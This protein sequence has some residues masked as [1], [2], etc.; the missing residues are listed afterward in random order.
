M[1]SRLKSLKSEK[2]KSASTTLSSF[3]DSSIRSKH[4]TVVDNTEKH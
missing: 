2:L 4:F 1:S 3:Q